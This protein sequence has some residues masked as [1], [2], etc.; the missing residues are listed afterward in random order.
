MKLDEK[1]QRLTRWM[2]V[3]EQPEPLDLDHEAQKDI[4][5]A[6]DEILRLRKA[7]IDALK[8]QPYMGTKAAEIC[9]ELRHALHE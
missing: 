1:I 3:N 8:H 6:A 9:T 2:L 7:I 5:W 4:A